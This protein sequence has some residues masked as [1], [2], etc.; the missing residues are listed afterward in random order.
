MLMDWS[1][2]AFQARVRARAAELGASIDTLLIE[3]GLSRDTLDHTPT[4]GRRIDTLEKLARSCRWSLA[5]LMGF[6][7]ISPELLRQAFATAD[8]IMSLL[9]FRPDGRDTAI[10][11]L[12]TEIYDL[13]VICEHRG[14]PFTDLELR[15]LEKWTADRW[16]AGA[17]S[18]S[19]SANPKPRRRRRLPTLQPAG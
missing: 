16:K 14:T 3:A 12:A 19:A 6:A 8:K 1:E 17:T 11:E 10:F 4:T 5:E 9:G 15:I 2:E 7:R 18:S 13:L